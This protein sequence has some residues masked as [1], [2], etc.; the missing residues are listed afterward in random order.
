MNAPLHHPPT[1]RTT[2]P[3]CG[4]G[5]GVLAQPDG[6]G[7]AVIAGDFV[8]SHG[9]RGFRDRGLSVRR[10]VL[11]AILVDCARAHGARV[12]EGARVFYVRGDLVLRSG[13]NG[14]SGT[15][16]HLYAI[17][18]SALHVVVAN[19]VSI[20]SSC[21]VDLSVRTI[22]GYG[23]RPSAGGGA[24]MPRRGPGLAMARADASH[25]PAPSPGRWSPRVA[26]WARRAGT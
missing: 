7:G 16:D 2:C 8:A 19:N 10:E 4:V 26:A 12:T 21:Q 15:T 20:D 9:F 13:G 18:S 24:P 11:D 6:H 22:P 23:T 1:V 17:G 3:Y 5:C 14:E 25:R